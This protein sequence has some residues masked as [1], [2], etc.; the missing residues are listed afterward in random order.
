M[1]ILADQLRHDAAVPSL[2]PA[3]ARLRSSAVQFAT[4]LT[5]APLCRPARTTLMTGQPVSVHG[6]RT[7]QAIPNPQHHPSHVRD[8]RE[9]GYR[10]VLVGKSHLSPGHGHLDDHRSVLEAWGFD[11]AVELPDAQQ[12]R[13]RSA[14]TDWLSA[15]TPRS[16]IDKAV[17][18]RDYLAHSDWLQPP[19]RPPWHLGLEDHLDVFC[20]RTAVAQIR[21]DPGVAPLYLQV[22]FPGPHPPFD[23]PS[24][25]WEHIDPDDPALPRTVPLEA[26]GPPLPS[27]QRPRARSPEALRTLRH[28]YFAKVALVDLALGQVLDALREAGLYDDAWILVTAD[29]GEL[30]GDHGLTGKVVPYEAA[31]RVPLIV[32][33]PGGVSPRIAEEAVDLV[34]VIDTIR[35]AAGVG[36]RPGLCG[37]ITAGAVASLPDRPIVSEAMELVTVR[38]ARHKLVWDRRHTDVVGFFELSRDPEER[39]NRVDDAPGAPEREW[40]QALAVEAAAPR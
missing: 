21:A 35:A 3:L 2:A 22:S 8:L 12:L 27:R 14:Y 30:L 1:L 16:A 4:C 19:D 34:D 6:Y 38:T 29:H 33:P 17:R 18:R 11:A 26:T 32:R 13:V 7:N 36:P 31:L 5:N 28:A 20:A 15:T 37:R 25:L 40:M 39:H 24:A 10:T 9:V 23:A